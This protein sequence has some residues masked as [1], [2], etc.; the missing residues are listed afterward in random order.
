MN[1]PNTWKITTE[2]DGFG[3]TMTIE[4]DSLEYIFTPAVAKAFRISLETNKLIRQK[5][6]EHLKKNES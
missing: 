3:H 1:E 4:D 5:A 2:K 6:L